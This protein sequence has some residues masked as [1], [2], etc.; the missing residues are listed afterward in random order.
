MVLT[1]DRIAVEEVAEVGF[2]ASNCEVY[3]RLDYLDKLHVLSLVQGALH[4]YGRLGAGCK[5]GAAVSIRTVG[6]AAPRCGEGSC[7]R[8]RYHQHSLRLAV[9]MP[10]PLMGTS[11]A[12]P[13]MV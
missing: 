11:R 13:S 4:V 6:P 12:R 8:T 2:S 10:L 5:R 9:K 7:T 3:F 1:Q